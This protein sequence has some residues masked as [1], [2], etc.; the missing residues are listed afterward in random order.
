MKHAPPSIMSRS[1]EKL[2]RYKDEP[3]TSCII[4][5]FSTDDK[6]D[7]ATICFEMIYHD[8]E[9]D[10]LGNIWSVYQPTFKVNWLSYGLAHPEV[11]LKRTQVIME[12]TEFALKLQD[13]FHEES[14]QL[15]QSANQLLEKK[16]KSEVKQTTVGLGILIEHLGDRKQMRLDTTRVIEAP[17]FEILPS[18]EYVVSTKD[19]KR[20]TITHEGFKRW[21]QLRRV[22]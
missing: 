12:A 19:G 8:H 22:G 14:Y 20:Y 17:L 10:H 13:I 4:V 6:N 1:M 16:D 3:N 9:V 2:A 11:Q 18:G 15:A 7:T 5:Y 21:A